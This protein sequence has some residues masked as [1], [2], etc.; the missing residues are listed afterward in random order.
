MQILETQ[1][2][3]IYKILELIDNNSS[4]KKVVKTIKTLQSQNQAIKRKYSEINADFSSIPTSILTTI[5]ADPTNVENIN[6]ASETVSSYERDMMFKQTRKQKR[7]KRM[8]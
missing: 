6:F 3:Q 7:F 1:K 8:Y 5:A 4:S 2:S